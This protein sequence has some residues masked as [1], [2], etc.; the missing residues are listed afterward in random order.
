MIKQAIPIIGSLLLLSGCGK[1][2]PKVDTKLNANINR[3]SQGDTVGCF[4]AG[5]AIQKKGSAVD[6]M[7]AREFYKKACEGNAVSG[8]MSM[9]AKNLGCK[10]YNLTR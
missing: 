10:Y 6:I 2:A 8:T 4:E 5:W 7:V 9:R 3:C 1:P